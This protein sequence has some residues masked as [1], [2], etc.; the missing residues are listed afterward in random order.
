MTT[1]IH[2]QGMRGVWNDEEARSN[3]ELTRGMR[4]MTIED[5]TYRLTSEGLV[6]IDRIGWHR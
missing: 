3:C 6:R 2:P 5:A 1:D 4:L